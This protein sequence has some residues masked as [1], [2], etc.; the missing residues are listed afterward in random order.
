MTHQWKQQWRN[1]SEKFIQLSPR[2]QYLIVLT[3]LVAIIFIIFHLFIDAK[4]T[5]HQ[6]LAKQIVQFESQNRILKVSAKEYQTALKVDPNTAIKDKITRFEKKLGEVDEKLLTLTTELISPV[7]MR[8]AL[9]ELLKL[10]QGVSLLSFELVGAEPLLDESK[11]EN[12]IASDVEQGALED[13]SSVSGMNLYRHGI[14]I[15]LSG[16]YFELRDYLQQLEQL[17]WKFFWQEFDLKV[18]EYPMS[19]LSIEIYS[20]GSKEAFVGV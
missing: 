12:S 8:L 2:E 19:E 1:Y 5:E 4:L 18:T 11:L 3:G 14:K 7:Q 20:L 16:R 10:E 17:P 13:V 6:R 9:F 15:T